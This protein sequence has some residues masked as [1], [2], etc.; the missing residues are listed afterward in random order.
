MN[1]KLEQ[2]S[3]EEEIISKL[4]EQKS[5][6]RQDFRKVVGE[7][8]KSRKSSGYLSNINLRSVYDEMVENGEL[9][10]NNG[11]ESLLV[12]KKMRSLSGVS[13][14]TVL[15]K[16]YPCPGQC[17]YCPTQENV[18]KSY[19]ADEPAVMRAILNKYDAL[20]QV[21]TR[22]TSLSKQGHPIDKIE[23]IVIGGTFN[24]L[25]KDY[26]EEFVKE[27]FDALNGFVSTNLSEAKLANEKA[28]SKCVGLTLETRP[29]FVTPEEAAW[30]RYLGATRVEMGVQSIFDDV[31]EKNARGHKVA[32]T[33]EATKLLK[34][35]GFKITYHLMPNLYGSDLDKDKK[36]FREVFQNSDFKPDYIKIYPCMVMANTP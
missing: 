34:N 28:K 24:Y 19:L 18:P 15:T 36:M 32:E 9:E 8:Y 13:V 20:N 31:L 27:C 14:I 26:Q 33:V 12:T 2:S 23:L 35:A 10:P 3:L 6:T 25:P 11:I 21:K 4:I 29:D 16:P 17:I 7:V 5:T 22:L 1:N 30:F